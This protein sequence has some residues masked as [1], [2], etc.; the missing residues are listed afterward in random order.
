MH[1]AKRYS[2]ALSKGLVLT[3]AMVGLLAACMPQEQ[4][5]LSAYPGCSPVNLKLAGVTPGSLGDDNERELRRFRAVYD[6]YAAGGDDPEHYQH[7]Q[8]ALARVKKDYVF[9]VP[10]AQLVDT[11]IDGLRKG[12]FKP[13]SQQRAKL[14]EASLDSMIG[15]LDP[16]S[17]YLNPEQF[18][19]MQVTIQGE[20]GGLGLFVS[21]ENSL[22]KV[23]SALDDTPASR[24]GIKAGDL[25]SHVDGQSIEGLTLSDAVKRMRGKPGTEIKLTVRRSG[26]PTFDVTLV[27]AIIRD[28]VKWRT[29]GNIGYI[30]VKGFVDRTDEDVR[31]ALVG[32]QKQLGQN[33]E[34]IVLD[35]RDNPGGLLEESVRLAD[36]FLEAGRIV[37]IRG[38]DPL[39]ERA[40]DALPGDV[41]GGRPLVVLINDGSASASEIVAGALQDRRRATV[42]GTRSFGKGSV[43]TIIPM[44]QEDALKF[45]TAMYYLPSCRTIQGQ[46]IEPDITVMEDGPEEKRRSEAS[47]PHALPASFAGTPKT[48]ATVD[49]AA[50]PKLSKEED[51]L[52]GCALSYLRAGSDDRFL[53]ALAPP[54]S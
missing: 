46:G 44:A 2:P 32:I 10:S 29:E 43:Q 45:T 5:L 15:E 31:A 8:A 41:I 36:A 42:M 30:R 48:R 28:V 11:A 13:H 49:S 16:H 54:K 52:L 51:P 7:F 35:L 22:V 12:D 19:E 47:L 34:G 17:A 27:R 23:D 9:D 25:I 6:E 20:W 39:S 1:R 26:A 37:S 18:K 40:Y 50:C 4:R 14:I 24:A 33:L 53:A 38:R 3:T 21:S